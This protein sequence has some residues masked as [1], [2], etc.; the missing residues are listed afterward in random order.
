MN[1]RRANAARIRAEAR[2]QSADEIARGG[3]E[4]GRRQLLRLLDTE[5]A[6]VPAADRAPVACRAGC[7]LCCHLRVMA[8]PAEVF[9]LLDYLRETLDEAAFA[10]FRERVRETDARLAGLDKKQVLATNLP[11][12]VL[13]DGRCSGYA[14]RPLNC[15]SYHSL[16]LGACQAS[17]DDPANPALDHP[18][19]AAVARVHEGA[20]AGY[21][22]G[23]ADAGYDDGQYELVTALAEAL[24][25]PAARQ[26]FDQRGRPFRRPSP[27]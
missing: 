11:C 14:A 3:P 12:P 16:D 23:L 18:Q 21:I 25:D 4:R 8:T 19:Y 22:A 6:R 15:R 2:A 7:D 9:G 1:D 27:V 5:L 17:F 24:D 13:V 26:R 20:Q 10:A